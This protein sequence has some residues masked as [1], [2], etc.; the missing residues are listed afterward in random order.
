MSTLVTHDEVWRLIQLLRPLAS[1]V[2]ER[3]CHWISTPNG[4]QGN[5]WCPSCGRAM[6][7]HLRRHE[8]SLRLRGD[9]ILDGG[10]R[11]AHDGPVFCAGCGVRLNG[12]LTE[13]GAE[14]ELE[15][16]NTYGFRPGNAHDAYELT[17]MLSALEYTSED[18]A[19]R[20][21]QAA[22]IVR[23]FIVESDLAGTACQE[24]AQ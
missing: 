20:A 11:T 15:H 8:K 9:Y 14:E 16:Y 5:E 22:D 3:E 2:D 10:W 1:T 6:V 24:G 21:K 12:S 19:G 18:R 7:R 13:Y 4:D 23:R 17:E